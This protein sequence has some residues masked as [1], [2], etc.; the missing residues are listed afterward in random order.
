MKKEEKQKWG[1]EFKE[2]LKKNWKYILISICFLIISMVLLNFAGNYA[3][4]KGVYSV[5]DLILDNLPSLNLYFLFVYGALA[6]IIF[7]FAYSIFFKTEKLHIIISQFSFL[8]LIRDF[9]L[10]LTH[11]KIPVDYIPYA[12]SGFNFFI[13]TNDLFFSGHTAVPFLAFLL[14]KDSKIKWIFLALTIMMGATVLL[15][16]VHYSIDV[17]A[18]PF[19]TYG[20]YKIGDWFFKKFR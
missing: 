13:F 19:I 3:D 1:T 6:V 9:F 2:S 20:C 12:S 11:L 14:F 8:I 4:K 18:A 7:F 10:I 15:M 5:G 16:H 17:F